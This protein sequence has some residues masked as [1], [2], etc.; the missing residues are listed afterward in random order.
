MLA[1]CAGDERTSESS[2]L[3]CQPGKFQ[4]R[5]PR[6]HEERER[7]VVICARGAHINVG[8]NR[9]VGYLHEIGQQKFADS[10][11]LIIET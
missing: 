10:S 1:G 8:Q 9:L 4:I 5:T 3:G 7:G 6:K 2:G 11:P